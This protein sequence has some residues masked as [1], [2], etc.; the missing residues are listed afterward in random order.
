M[1]NVR[2]VLECTDDGSVGHV[3]TGP[4]YGDVQLHEI[5]LGRP[6]EARHGGDKKPNCNEE[7][8]V[9]RQ[10]PGTFFWQA[11]EKGGGQIRP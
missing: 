7:P 4:S 8:N 5:N 2:D 11:P 10:G 9:F 1:S 3:V 6:Q